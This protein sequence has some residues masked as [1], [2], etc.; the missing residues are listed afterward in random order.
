MNFGQPKHLGLNKTKTSCRG[1][2]EWA[3][4]PDILT[5]GRDCRQGLYL[6]HFI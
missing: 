4:T 6:L 2:E 5:L 1:R 3:L